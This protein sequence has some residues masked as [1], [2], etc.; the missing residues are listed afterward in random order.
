VVRKVNKK[1]KKVDGVEKKT[2][3]KHKMCGKRAFLKGA[4]SYV[5]VIYIENCI[6]Y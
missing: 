5:P 6:L 4:V 2:V 1:D 3:L